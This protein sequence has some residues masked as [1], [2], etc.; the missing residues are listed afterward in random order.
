MR[1]PPLLDGDG[2]TRLRPCPQNIGC[3]FGGGGSAGIAEPRKL[4][5]IDSAFP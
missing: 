1:R 4:D 2:A 5:K 3:L